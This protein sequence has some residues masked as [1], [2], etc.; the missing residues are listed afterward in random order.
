MRAVYA[1]PAD[2][3]DGKKLTE[4]SCVRCHGADGISATKGVPHL[5]GQRAAYLYAKLRAYQAGTRG[6]HTM[7]SAV[8]FLNDAALVRVA[9]YYA[10]LE[11]PAPAGDPAKP[12]PANVDPLAAAKASAAACGGCH[13]ESGVT[14]IPGT[15]SLVGFDPKY[16]IAAM[17]GYRTGQRRHDL[18]KTLAAPLGE[19]DLKNIAIF[20]ALQKPMRAQTPVSGNPAA[21]KAAAA[22]CSG[23]HGEN[24]VSTNPANPSLAGQD[25][26]YFVAALKAYKDGSRKEETMKL[27]VSSLTERAIADMGAYYAQQEPRAPKVEK[28]LT[29]SQWAQRCDRCHGV[30]GNST[31]P[32]VA[33]IAAQRPEYLQKALRAYQGG[34]R[35][36]SVMAAMSGTLG[37]ADIDNLAAY[38]SRQKARGV[39]FLTLPAR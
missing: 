9:A 27:A 6:D 33:A 12:A 20:Y 7:E 10:S 38:Y 25:A 21:G 23:C 34:Q 3:A 39:V 28:P 13:G 19:S 5:A 36:S 11:P 29:L 31:D 37:D 15:P 1:T 22:A 2:V 26:Q 4:S 17:N 14:K 32:R 18:M 8:K 16:F 30:N 35:K 24:G